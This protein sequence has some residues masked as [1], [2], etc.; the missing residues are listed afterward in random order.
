MGGIAY[1]RLGRT[2]ED[3]QELLKFYFASDFS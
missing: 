2:K 3:Q 1:N